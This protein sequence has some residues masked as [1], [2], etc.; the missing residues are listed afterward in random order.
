MDVVLPGGSR[1]AVGRGM[2][3]V[4]TEKA[5]QEALA[6]MQRLGKL[7]NRRVAFLDTKSRFKLKPVFDTI[8]SKVAED[9]L[10]PDGTVLDQQAIDSGLAL[11]S[12][13]AEKV[14]PELGDAPPGK[15]RAM[16]DLF[17]KQARIY[18]KNGSGISV[19][20]PE[21]DAYIRTFKKA[22][23]DSF[24]DILNSGDKRPVDLNRESA[25][26]RPTTSY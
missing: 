5:K 3:V 14:G 8:W 16:R 12:E 11:I 7:I 10:F 22:A 9:G 26:G 1:D 25:S 18:K 2:V 23:A 21:A 13:I 6:K 17:Q 24:R 4:S 19:P 15:I 20:T